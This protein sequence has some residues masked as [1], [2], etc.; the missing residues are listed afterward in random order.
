VTKSFSPAGRFV[1]E[2]MTSEPTTSPARYLTLRD[3]VRVIRRHWIMIVVLALAGAGAGLATSIH[4]RA[5]YTAT[6]E[7]ALQDPTAQLSVVGLGSPPPQTPA[8]L[9]ATNA[10]TLTGRAVMNQVRHQLKTK[11][12]AD[13]L[14]GSISAQ[15]SQQSGLLQISASGSSPASASALANAAASALVSQDNERARAQFAR[16]ASNVR[17]QIANLPPQL[18][19]ASPASPLTYYETELARLQ[20]LGSVA[21]SGQIAKLAQPADATS[22]AERTRGLL[23]GLALG[24]LL[25]IVVAF[26]RDSMDRRLRD[27]QDIDSSFQLPLLGYVGKRSMGRVAG[28]NG[29]RAKHRSD[30]EQFKILRRNLELLDHDS[31][32]RSV[33]VTSTVAGEGKTTVAS[34]LALAMAAAGKRTLLVDCDLRRPTLAARLGIESSPGISEYLAGAASPEQILRTVELPEAL[35]VADSPDGAPSNGNGSVWT[36]QRLVCIPAGTAT[37]RATELLGS[38]RFSE[39]IAQVS[40][41]YDAVVLDSSPLLSVAD[42]LE[43]LPHMDAVVVCARESRTTR[44]QAQAARATLGR[45]PARPAGVVVTGVRPGAAGD[46]RYA[47]AYGYS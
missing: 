28:A 13:A 18:R 40:A 15:V 33:L 39:F 8:A 9:A 38:P 45:F 17:R 41:T 32:P 27:P 25:G 12:S 29:T 14:A 47:Y 34:S 35:A 3:Y 20:T 21:T 23:I 43:M 30:L 42:T 19:S 4:K 6:S 7:V 26:I 2:D 36:P 5:V 24:L 44:G 46:E 37:S 22:S 1:S 16:V 10:E 31:P 11:L